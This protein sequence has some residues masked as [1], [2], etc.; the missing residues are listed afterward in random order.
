MVE[1]LHDSGAAVERFKSAAT[2]LPEASTR[3]LL[4]RVETTT[5]PLTLWVV[6]LEL[7][8]RQIPPCLRTPYRDDSPELCFVTWLADLHWLCQ[9]NPGHTTTFRSWHRL[10]V[11]EQASTNWHKTAVWVYRQGQAKMNFYFSK[12]LGLTDQQRQPL[13]LLMSQPMRADRELLRAMPRHRE[14][15]LTHA[16]SN[17]DKGAVHSPQ[18]VAGRRSEILRIHL[19]GGRSK[20][21]TAEWFNLLHGTKL[22]RQL[23]AKQINHIQAATGLKKL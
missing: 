10:F 16:L 22:T 3:E 2:R 17:R 15:I 19:L 11:Y 7:D 23:V 12:G 4:A 20:S 18:D 9:R 14:R 8:R 1:A 6:H 21:R 5:D 13:A